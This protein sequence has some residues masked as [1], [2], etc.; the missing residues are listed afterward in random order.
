MLAAMIPLLFLVAAA[1]PRVLVLELEAVGV[2]PALARSVDPLVLSGAAV[3]G[4]SLISQREI[5][6][7]ASVEA[8]KAQL[9]CDSSSCLSEL[10]GALGARLVLFGSV[11]RLGS[12]TTVSFSAYDNATSAIVRDSLAVD[13]VGALPKQLP[14]RVH[15]LV[16]KA[17]HATATTSHGDPSDTGAHAT[18]AHV[19]GSASNHA[20]PVQSD[21]EPPSTMF[22]AGLACAIVGGAALLAGGLMAT[23]NEVTIQD[24]T[25]LGASKRIAQEN[26]VVGVAVGGGGAVVAGLGALLLVIE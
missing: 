21:A 1:D 9:G 25:A 18:D 13:D 26:G 11:S 22:Y 23:L 16:L 17:L 10:A 20:L 2:E 14:E 4:V 6:T 7:I 15:A 12:T 8:E 5:K 3:D 24:P 19:N